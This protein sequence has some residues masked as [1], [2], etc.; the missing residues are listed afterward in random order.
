MNVAQRCSRSF[1]FDTDRA[2]DA[3]VSRS[4]NARPIS[5]S[6]ALSAPIIFGCVRGRHALTRVRYRRRA[7]RSLVTSSPRPHIHY[8]GRAGARQA[9]DEFASII[10]FGGDSR[11]IYALA[12]DRMSGLPRRNK[13]DYRADVTCPESRVPDTGGRI[14]AAS[15]SVFD[16]TVAFKQGNGA[17]RARTRRRGEYLEG[18]SLFRNAFISFHP[19]FEP[20]NCPSPAAET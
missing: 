4:D 10:S 11:L 12:R 7:S 8:R 13:P 2:G 20:M 6:A 14:N 17:V 19:S 1:R 9:R 16:L 5:L 18:G 15:L 3:P